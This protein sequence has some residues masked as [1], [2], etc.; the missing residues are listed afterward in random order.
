[1][2]TTFTFASWNSLHLFRK[3][4]VHILTWDTTVSNSPSTM[5]GALSW[6]LLMK[7]YISLTSEFQCSRVYSLISS[8]TEPSLVPPTSLHIPWLH[9]A[10]SYPVVWPLIFLSIWNLSDNPQFT[11]FLHL[12]SIPEY[13]SSSNIHLHWGGLLWFSSGGNRIPCQSPPL[14]LTL[15]FQN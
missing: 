7:P 15:I 13:K 2:L 11:P 3:H 1:M 5:V 4:F 10:H 8:L 6:S 12:D 9:Q 14:H